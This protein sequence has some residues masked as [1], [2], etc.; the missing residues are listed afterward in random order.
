MILS[1]SG[2]KIEKKRDDVQFNGYRL[3]PVGL[4]IKVRLKVKLYHAIKNQ[5]FE[6]KKYRILALLP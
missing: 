3:L 2:H 5:E 6:T 4:V 1:A